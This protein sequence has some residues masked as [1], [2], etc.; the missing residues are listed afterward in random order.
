MRPPAAAVQR[1]TARWPAARQIRLDFVGT[2][3]AELDLLFDQEF[4]PRVDGYDEDPDL[5]DLATVLHAGVRSSKPG[6]VTIEVPAN[7]DLLDALATELVTR[8][9]GAD[10][11]GEPRMRA[12]ETLCSK[13]LRLAYSL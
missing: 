1:A 6:K 8:I 5:Y 7:R 9:N 4:D 2:A 3:A 10:E 12:F 13:V 11:R